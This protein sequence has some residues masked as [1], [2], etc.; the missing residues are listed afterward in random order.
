MKCMI[1]DDEPLAIDV[2]ESHLAKIPE[3][4]LVATAPNAIVASEKLKNNKVDLLFMDIQMPEITGLDFFRSLESPPLVIFTTAYPE[5]AIEGFELDAIDYL[6]K[7]ISFDRFQKAVKKAEEY[8]GYQR[9]Q[10]IG[11]PEMEEDFIFVKANQKQIRVS[12][13]DILYIEAFADYVK[14]Y[15]AEKRIVTLQTMKKME[16]T[17][18][19]DRFC[20]IHRSFIV[21]LAHVSAFSGNELEING[22]K[23]P[24]GKNYKD[25]FMEYMRS[26]NIL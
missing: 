20:R 4:E 22:V 24:I 8:F 6:L 23:L 15:T 2:L 9:D 16:S 21:G 12:Y 18:P 10:A 26:R 1:V 19:E 11:K 25:R 17:L 13:S 7:P 5:Y 3:L 14:I